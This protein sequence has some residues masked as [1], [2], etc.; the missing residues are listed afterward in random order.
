MAKPL[1][2]IISSSH[3]E[4]LIIILSLFLGSFVQSK[5]LDSDT[6]VLRLIKKSIDPTSIP[7][8][9]YIGSWDFSVDP[10][11]SSGGQFLGILCSY[12]SDN[13][14][15]RVTAIDLDP[16]GYD[17]FLAPAIGNLT[18]LTILNLHN[19]KFRGPIPPTISNLK[20]LTIISLS[21]NFF[22]GS[23]PD[24]ISQLKQLQSIDL[25]ENN[26][27]GFIPANIS[28]LRSLTYLSLSRNSL[29]GR[30]PDLSGLWRL[31]IL[32][33]SINQFY[34]IIPKLPAKLRTLSASQNAISGHITPISSLQLLRNLDLSNNRLSGPIR[35]E[36]L[37]L[38]Q[39]IRINISVNHFTIFEPIRNPGRE[40]HLQLLDAHTNQ[41]HG[42]LPASLTMIENLTSINLSHNQFSGPIPMEYGEKLGS[43]W[44][45]L[46][47][48]NNFLTGNLPQRFSDGTIKP[49]RG[50]LAN[51]C[52]SCAPTIPLCSGGQRP[53]SECVSRNDGS[54]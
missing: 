22:T 43:P 31:N 10:C 33:I 16:I 23:I 6:Q 3:S 5:T 14:S 45:T 54:Q 53:A 20:K 35:Q 9:S 47:L 12:P 38:P 18:E 26:L 17:G 29:S 13:S 50:S 34:G 36:V 37:T 32:D 25:S 24:E 21:Q 41:L 4:T 42:H 52:L 15:S 19:N 51:N 28:G 30:I 46:F 27:S 2:S 49:V 7:S 11:E 39:I 40:T 48:D 8:Y 1:L 44:K